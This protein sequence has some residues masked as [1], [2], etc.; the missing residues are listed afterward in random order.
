MPY[1][2]GDSV[3]PT[4]EALMRSRYSAYVTE[5][6]DYLKG[7]LWPKHQPGFGFAATARWAAESHWTGLRVLAKE[8][9]DTADR[10]GT[11]LFEAKYLSGGM[12]QTHREKSRFRKKA[13][14][15]FY[16]EALE[17]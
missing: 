5:N 13:G 4:A 8:K 16:V 2:N 6:I 12:L 17:E 3:P 7:T 14:R 9:G 11:V 15:W 1:L 10:E